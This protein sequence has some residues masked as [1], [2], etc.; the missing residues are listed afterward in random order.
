MSDQKE[1]KRLRD[2]TEEEFNAL[3]DAGILNTIYPGAPEDYSVIKGPVKPSPLEEPDFSGLISLCK[4]YLNEVEQRKYPDSNTQHYIFEEAMKA[5]Y[6]K[7]VWDYI[8][9]KMR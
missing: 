7:D 5:V 8:N 4:S 6:G 2:L 9:H 3:K 1:P